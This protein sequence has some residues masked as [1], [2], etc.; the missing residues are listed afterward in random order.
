MLKENGMSYLDIL[1]FLNLL[2]CYLRR[3]NMWGELKTGELHTALCTETFWVT[4]FGAD[5]EEGYNDGLGRS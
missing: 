3:K 5:N 4:G 1:H 2:Q